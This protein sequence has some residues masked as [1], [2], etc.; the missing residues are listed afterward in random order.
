MI[1]IIEGKELDKISPAIEENHVDL[2]KKTFVGIK[3]SYLSLKTSVEMYYLE[4]VFF[5]Y[6][7]IQISKIY[8]EINFPNES[9]QHT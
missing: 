3:A 9:I 6:D 1:K 8:N 2:L 7:Y 4:E 5:Q